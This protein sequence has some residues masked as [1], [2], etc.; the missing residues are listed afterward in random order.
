MDASSILAAG[1]GVLI[2]VL[3]ILIFFIVVM[4]KIYTKAG[5]PG[6]AVLVPIYNI[7]V[8][9]QIIKR[10]GW[11]LL[12]Y[13]APYLVSALLPLNLAWIGLILMLVILVISIMDTHRLSTAFG[14]GAGFTVGLILLGI[15]F[16]P[17]LAF[18]SATYGGGNLS[19]SSAPIDQNM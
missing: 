12:V 17:I 5:Q 19:S 6:W 8:Y 10:P 16:Y 14:Q 15:V 9:T 1:A 18:G 13:L 11:W 2:F 7:Y 4:W 3:A